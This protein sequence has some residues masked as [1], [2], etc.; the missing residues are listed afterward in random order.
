M[1]HAEPGGAGAAVR[2]PLDPLTVD[3]VGRAAAIVRRER[4]VDDRWRI[5]SIELR[6]PA[7][8]ELRGFTDGDPIERSA[9]VVCWSRDDGQAYKATVDL[10]AGRV[11]T[12]EHRPG[13]QPNM[14]VD[15]YHECDEALRR[16]PRVI[17]ALARRGITDMSLVLVDVWAYAGSLVP[18]QHAD[19]RI[20]W[21]D[22]WHRNRPG[23]NPYANHVAGLHPIV[24]LNTMDL[25]DLGDSRVVP[26]A[27]TMGEYAADLVP[28]LRLRD[29]VRPLHVTQPDGVSF[30]LDGHRLEW[31]RWS[32]RIGFNHREGL[33]VHTVGYE[34]GGRVRPVAHRL[35]FAE[36][37]VPYRDPTGDHERRTAF[38]IG[39]WGLGFMT[40]S[41]ELGCDCLGEIAYLDATLHDSRGEP[42]T[43]RNAICIHEEDAGVLWK[44]VDEAAGAE[45]RRMRRLVVSFHATV[46]NYEYLVAWR[47][48]QDGSIECEVRATGIMVTTQF[49]GDQPPYGVLVDE[50]TYAPFHQHFVIARLDLDVDG[51]RNTVYASDSEALPPGPGN[52]HGLAMV[53]RSTP[54][55]TERDGRQDYDWQRQRAWKV[56][57]DD[58]T[59]RLGTAVGYKLVPG[60]AIP[61]MLDPASPVLQR[62]QAIAHTLWVTPYAEDERW[63]CGEFPTQSATD[64]GLP[65]WT[66]ADRPIEDA[67]VV[68]WYVFGINHVTRPED[69]PVMPVDIVSF[70]LKPA[71][72]FDRNPALDVP[73]SHG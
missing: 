35:S 22:V 48:H 39:E 50:R 70:W 38:D 68:L 2:H 11:A 43:I 67:D 15:E 18:P 27:P 40:T 20:G 54:L 51:E 3:E 25:L 10:G 28:G 8:A 60:A 59:N 6:E 4:G 69:W 42:Y 21:A 49:E 23:S 62:A 64:A 46:A 71:G 57:N 47:F 33:V 24:D 41:L 55:R 66:S 73:P 72:F 36:M 63:P 32:M 56:V 16:D 44:H 7:K 19:R 58:V 31:Q 9:I 65:A 12:W 17:E 30:T 1:A 13:E 53:Q 45:V 61:A 29:D 5:A 34:D 52:P 26:P 37:V 14:T